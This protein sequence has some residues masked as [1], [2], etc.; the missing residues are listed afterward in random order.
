MSLKL[1]LEEAN[2]EGAAPAPATT[3]TTESS[4]NCTRPEDGEADSGGGVFDGGDDGG[5]GGAGR[6]RKD[7]Y[8]CCCCWAMVCADWPHLLAD[9]DTNQCNAAAAV[10]IVGDCVAPG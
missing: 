5:G 6:R 10:A 4:L 3:T 8:R 9:T 7:S 2:L 1:K